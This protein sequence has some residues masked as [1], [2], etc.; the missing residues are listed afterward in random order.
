MKTLNKLVRDNIVKI[1]KKQ[2]GECTHHIAD[3]R[4]YEKRLRDK[5]YEEVEEFFEEPCKEEMADIQEV[6]EALMVFYSID[7]YDM[8]TTKLNKR[9]TR[10]AFATR[11]VLDTVGE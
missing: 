7:P 2:G 1:I 6:L 8:E 3:W 4:E 5:L 9:G 10:G 11:L